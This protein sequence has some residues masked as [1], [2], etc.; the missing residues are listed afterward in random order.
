MTTIWHNPRC[1]KSR[2]TLA[3]LE[4]NGET[5]NVIKYLETPPSIDEIRAAL[6]ALN[7]PAIQIM[8]TGEKTFKN[9]G[10]SKIDPDETLITAM[11]ENPILIE[12]PIVFKND[13]AAIGRPPED[14][15]NI[16]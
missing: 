10:L 7:V 16:L 11:A 5:P 15:L 6:T 8:R 14:V 1:T 4:E 12:R 3:L 9:L 2:Q 13:R